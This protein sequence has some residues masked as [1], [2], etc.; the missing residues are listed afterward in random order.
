M[1]WTVHLEQINQLSHHQTAP[2]S[3]YQMRVDNTTAG[4]GDINIEFIKANR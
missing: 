2:C 1:L 4:V 3:D